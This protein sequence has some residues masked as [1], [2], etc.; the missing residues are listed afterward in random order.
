MFLTIIISGLVGMTAQVIA[1]RQLTAVFQGNELTMGILFAS[2]LL[3]TAL[4]SWMGTKFSRS[5]FIAL[6]V[7]V[8]IQGLLL[9]FTLY[10]I[11][12]SRPILGI[13][14][15][16][17]V[18]LFPIILSSLFTI[19]PIALITGLC[20]AL[21]CQ[22]WRLTRTSEISNST[23]GIQQVYVAEAVGAVLGGISS[24]ILS[25]IIEPFPWVIMVSGL[26][27]GAGLWTMLSFRKVA[28]LEWG[29]II[30]IGLLIAILFGKQWE[31]TTLKPLFKGQQIIAKDESPYGQL[32]ATRLAE[33]TSLYINGVKEA[34]VPDPFSAEDVCHLALSLHPNPATVLLIGGIVGEI[35]REILKHPSV[36]NL[37]VVEL[38]PNLIYL[39]ESVFPDSVT[40]ILNRHQIKVWTKDGRRFILTSK[41]HYDVILMDLPDP[42]SAQVNRYYTLEWFQE[43][44]QHLTN[45]GIFSFSVRSSESSMNREQSRFLAC[46]YRTLQKAIPYVKVIPGSKSHFLASP[47]SSVLQLNV[48]DIL[49]TLKSQNIET[50]YISEAYLPDL[51]QPYRMK[52][53]KDRI[54]N[55]D[56]PINR[57]FH[58][59]GYYTGLVLWDTQFRTSLKGLFVWL[60]KIPS[61]SILIVWGLLTL[62]LLGISI[63]QR[64]K[65]KSVIPLSIRTAIFTVGATE[66]GLEILLILGFQIVFGVAYGWVAMIV[67]AF[68]AGI[69]I[70]ARLIP[71]ESL[72]VPS[73]VLTRRNGSPSTPSSSRASTPPLRIRISQILCCR[74][75]PPCSIHL[76]WFVIIQSTII[77]LPLLIWLLMT[78]A[79]IL[80][81]LPLVWGALFFGIGALVAGTLGGMQFPIAT[82]LLA[83]ES[84]KA[85][86]SGEKGIQSVRIG[87]R[88]YALDLLGSAL[89]AILISAFLVP[90]WGLGSAFMILALMNIIPIVIFLRC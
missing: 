65:G 88:L 19:L 62:L 6:G 70:G 27:V 47:D 42:L 78:Q 33:Q 63:T 72:R 20:F 54:T 76:R 9:P 39:A 75:S 57:D 40:K 86:Q 87:G 51:L 41:Q 24:F 46:I 45:N 82:A 12:Y 85:S 7:A 64:R 14:A 80:V 50:V 61:Y 68:M 73:G 29:A 67:T 10:L 18:G 32:T 69:A 77:I 71:T 49:R 58:P 36:K 83:K 35:P 1:L 8:A 11:R 23:I 5:G 16:Q 17:T 74:V 53:L 43:V 59:V 66:I 55:I 30:A 48:D 56:A 22:A 3:W 2:W 79:K 25:P 44:R 81:G 38:D 4:G 28:Y 21:G 13:Q 37:D 34:T 26:G 52:Q 89:G 31:L 90:L 84:Q 15:G 60:R